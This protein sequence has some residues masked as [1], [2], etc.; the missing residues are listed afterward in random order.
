MRRAAAA[1]VGV[2]CILAGQTGSVSAG[3]NDQR[4]L[5]LTRPG[6]PTHVV[7]TGTVNASGTVTDAFTLNPDGT[8]DNL[9]TQVFPDG[10]LFFHA[11]GTFAFTLNPRTCQGEGDVVG[12]FEITGGTGA[13]EGASGEGV[14][15]ISL[16]FFFDKT[17]T[18]CSPFPARVS[19]VTRATGTLTIP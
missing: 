13:Y 6:E 18:G 14:D 7:A 19:G 2:L 15:R 1:A 9:A 17:D 10:N 8:F 5:V 12:P 16:H 4:W 11:S 3:T